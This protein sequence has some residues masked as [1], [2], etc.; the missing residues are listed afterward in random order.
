ML[1]NPPD[2]NQ[3]QAEALAAKRIRI[4]T[5]KEIAAETG[6]HYRTILAH[7]R[8]GHLPAKRLGPKLWQ[9]NQHGLRAYLLGVIDVRT[10]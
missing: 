8:S 5:P 10:P 7:I 9:I 1:G 4:L 2:R 6:L 3:L